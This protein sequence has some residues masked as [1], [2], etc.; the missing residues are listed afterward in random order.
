MA[1]RTDFSKL[2]KDELLRKIESKVSKHDL[3]WLAES[4]YENRIDVQAMRQT[5]GQSPHR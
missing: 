5:F 2:S 1:T 4:L 3:A